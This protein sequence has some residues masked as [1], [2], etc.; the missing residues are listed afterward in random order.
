[1]KAE[2]YHADHLRLPCLL[3]LRNVLPG[4]ICNTEDDADSML[5]HLHLEHNYIKTTDISS[6]AFSCIRS[7]S[8]IVL[9]PQD[10][11]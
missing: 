2:E 6:Y 11:K 3:L 10:I 1:M 9:K 4:Q 8:S 7:Y 5:G